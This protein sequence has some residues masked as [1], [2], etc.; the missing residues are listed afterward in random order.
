MQ[1]FVHEHRVIIHIAIECFF[2]AVLI[3]ASWSIWRD[4]KAAWPRIKELMRAE[5]DDQ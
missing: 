2:V 1:D 5:S 3:F 4:T